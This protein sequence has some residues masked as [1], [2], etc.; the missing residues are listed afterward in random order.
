MTL[1]G[2]SESIQR[3]LKGPK[4]SSQGAPRAFGEPKGLPTNAQRTF[5]EPNGHSQ[6]TQRAFKERAKSAKAAPWRAF[7]AHL[8][9]KWNNFGLLVAPW[10][11]KG[12]LVKTL[13]FT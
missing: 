13:V 4:G 6:G 3:T 9:L 5:R 10:S 7:G 1:K 12:D 8:E 2:D 11:T